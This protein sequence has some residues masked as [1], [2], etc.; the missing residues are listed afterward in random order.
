MCR[1]LQEST[2]G[3]EP[4]TN[5]LTGRGVTIGVS[6]TGLDTRSCFFYDPQGF[7]FDTEGKRTA[8]ERDTDL[9]VTDPQWTSSTRATSRTASRPSIAR[10]PVSHGVGTSRRRSQNLSRVCVGYF[11]LM[12]DGSHKENGESRRW[13]LTVAVMGGVADSILAPCRSRCALGGPDCRSLALSLHGPSC[14][15]RHRVSGTHVCGIA[16][17]NAEGSGPALAKAGVD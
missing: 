7:V 6:D 9:T 1:H 13:R 17:G 12:D 4:F 16:A 15:C 14:K 10:S 2:P 5:I 8:A 11:N 3:A